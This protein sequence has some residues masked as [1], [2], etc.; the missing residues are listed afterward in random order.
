L[1]EEQIKKIQEMVDGYWK[2]A[3]SKESVV[4]S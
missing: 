3:K 1:S 4:E 2:E